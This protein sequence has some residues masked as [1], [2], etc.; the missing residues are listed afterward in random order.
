M[1]TE[2]GLI[3]EDATVE[4]TAAE[5]AHL[6]KLAERYQIIKRLAFKKAELNWK[7]EIQLYGDDIC[8]YIK[9]VE[10]EKVEE[11]EK[12]LRAIKAKEKQEAS[13]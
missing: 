2:N 4:I 6:V 9:F 11:E 13:K 12:R 8:D 7:N 1:L 5:Y 3:K 10:Q